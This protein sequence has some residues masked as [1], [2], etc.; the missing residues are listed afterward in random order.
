[1]FL[2]NTIKSRPIKPRT[3]RS[4]AFVRAS[5]Y[6]IWGC[7]RKYS[8][9][10]QD[11]LFRFYS[12]NPCPLGLSVLVMEKWH[13]VSPIIQ[14]VL[15]FT[16]LSNSELIKHRSESQFYSLPWTN[17]LTPQNFCILSHIML[18]GMVSLLRVVLRIKWY[19]MFLHIKYLIK[20]YFY[21][22]TT[23][24]QEMLL[25]IDF[26]VSTIFSLFHQSVQKIF[27]ANMHSKWLRRLY[28]GLEYSA[29]F[30]RASSSAKSQKNVFFFR[31]CDNREQ[32]CCTSN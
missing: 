19:I 32:W 31:T 2:L 11:P 13:H 3:A 7:G 9:L 21:R 16:P 25:N 22:V 4:F 10:G 28:C 23:H 26:S 14:I 5:S 15:P 24:I 18:I 29:S 20:W 6:P 8:G 27:F 17:H 1:M 30:S 12:P